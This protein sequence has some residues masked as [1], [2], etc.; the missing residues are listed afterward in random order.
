MSTRRCVAATIA[1]AIVATGMLSGCGDD[2]QEPPDSGL[3]AKS[4]LTESTPTSTL[5]SATG[6]SPT[7][8]TRSGRDEPPLPAAAQAPG[9]AGAKAFVAYYIKL[10]NYA[11]HTGEIAPIK[12]YGQACHHCMAF[13][14]LAQSTYQDGGWFR[15]GTW[16]P[17]PGSWLVF[18]S[19]RGFLVG[20]NLDVAA[21]RQR[22]TTDG[23]VQDYP[24]E[25]IGRDFRLV[26]DGTTWRVI[27]MKEPL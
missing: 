22:A 15:G 11:Q 3:P 14:R 18:R 13:A 10:L 2:D 17:V 8:P 25:R 27:S 1:A 23:K 4:E 26:N 20:L 19:G 24:A 7:D 9:K 6:T 5:P 16:T 12:E 21:S